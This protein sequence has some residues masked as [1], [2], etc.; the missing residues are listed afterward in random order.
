MC[1]YIMGHYVG[2]KNVVSKECLMASKKIENKIIFIAWL[3][4]CQGYQWPSRLQNTTIN[5]L[6][7]SHLTY[8]NILELRLPSLPLSWNTD[9]I[10]F[11]KLLFYPSHLSWCPP[12]ILIYSR[13][14]NVGVC[15]NSI[16]HPLLFIV[17][18]FKVPNFK[19][20]LNLGPFLEL[21]PLWEPNLLV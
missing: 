14:L 8:L 15:H 7:S 3:S 5:P 13:L 10:C 2:I 21:W 16:Q 20:I 11:P 18:F 9:F 19:S 6:L 4:V 1:I 12:L 17:R